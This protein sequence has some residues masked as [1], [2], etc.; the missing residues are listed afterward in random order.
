MHPSQYCWRA[1]MKTHDRLIAVAWLLVAGAGYV[2]GP[3]LIAFQDSLASSLLPQGQLAGLTVVFLLVCLV[4]TLLFA[5]ALYQF[6]A[7]RNLPGPEELPDGVYLILQMFVCQGRRFF[8]VRAFSNED[9]W[10]VESNQPLPPLESRPLAPGERR[11]PGLTD[12][13]FH[14]KRGHVYPAYYGSVT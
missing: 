12:D 1:K 14:V 6:V 8:K 3:L 13:R 5:F 4:T 7:R 9:E 2:G 10:L 11:H